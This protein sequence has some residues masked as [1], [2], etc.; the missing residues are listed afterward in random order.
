[1]SKFNKTNKQPTLT[2]NEAGGMAYKQSDK[3]AFASLL[4]T[5]FLNDQFYR[6]GD[7]TINQIVKGV[8]DL[9]DPLFAAKS[10][11]YARD[12]FGMRST[13][14]VVAGELADLAKGTD[15]GKK[16][17]E[18]IVVR[19]DDITEIVSYYFSKNGRLHDDQSKRGLPASMRKGFGVVLN[20]AD[21]YQLAKYR[22]ENKEWKLVDVFNMIHPRASLK[23]KAAFEQL[24][25][26]KLRSKNTWNTQL[27]Q[28]GQTAKTEEAKELAK[29][30]VWKNFIAKR[31]RIEYF[32]LLR[33]IRNIQE[34]APEYLDDALALLTNP[35]LIKKS[36]ELPFRFSTAIDQ[37][38]N[39]NESGAR[40]VLIA[41]NKAIDISMDNVP[42]FDGTTLIAVDNSGSM[43]G[44]P[45]K[46]A[47]LFAI[48]ILKANPDADLMLFSEEAE[49]KNLN[50]MDSTLTLQNQLQR[51]FNGGGTNFNSIFYKANK[52]Y[53]RIITLSDMQAWIGQNYWGT[54]PTEGYAKYRTRMN[55]DPNIFSFDLAGH[56]SV[57]FPKDRIYELAGFS[58]KVFDI[59]ALLE[60]DRNALIN[61]INNI[62]L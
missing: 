56:G 9:H 49:Y 57:Q 51:M 62:Q 14:H 35:T 4:L 42:K 23:N 7:E 33:N 20:K 31:E 37:F 58:D 55:A 25:A 22:G 47:S 19:L 45:F 46:I 44:Q 11:I 12:K 3:V 13:S 60:T 50:T 1:M 18:K 30:D 2:I 48:A 17:Y 26:D 10:A 38:E 28:A 29:K 59:M 54:K 5:S 6:S 36:R 39:S 27:T 32:A 8:R 34:Q 16:F 43:G 61:E 53:D 24:I 41:L 52:A 15:W 40:K 21:E